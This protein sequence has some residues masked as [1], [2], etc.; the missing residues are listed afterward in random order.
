MK[1]FRKKK[2][3]PD[4][5][6][7]KPAS[8]DSDNFYSQHAGHAPLDEYSDSRSVRETH[9]TSRH[10]PA[11]RRESNN[12]A[13]DWALAVLLLRAVL[14]IVLL[15]GGFFV[16]KLVLNRM[17][18]P[19]DKERQRWEAATA[20][21]EQSSES[22]VIPVGTP[23]AP[24]TV[25]DS[26]LIEQRIG[27]WDLAAQLLH[28]AEGLERRGI[29]EDAAQRLGQVLRI[30]PD[31]RAAQQLLVDIYMRR[32]LYAEAIPLCIRLLDQNSQQPELQMSLLKALMASGQNAAVGM[33]AARML[34]DQPNHAGVLSI[35]AA[36][37]MKLG[38]K[39]AALA[40]FKRV[41]ENEDK[42]KGA[43]ES[44]G[45]IY[46][47]QNDYLNAIPY[48]LELTKLDPK[49]DYY[50]MLARCYA[51]QK[52]AGKAVIF[53]GQAA[54][55]FGGEAVSSWFKDPLFDLVRET[56][57]FRSFTDR[58]IGIEGRKA[59]EAISKRTAEKREEPS[60]GLELP[61]RPDMNPLQPRK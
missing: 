17:A 34:L 30:M 7:A 44:C 10:S 2:A 49:P 58:I 37:Q 22:S 9:R 54:G 23:G 47:D 28:S 21:M 57:E 56:P 60:G 29:D 27:Q 50:Q 11:R 16:L 13:S 46:F 31:N 4:E 3:R 45:K 52:E 25:V 59:I 41:L 48:Y 32:G 43:L 42:N 12:R 26:A 24:K 8:P 40:L 1:F 14:I 61:T 38:N 33:L 36:G 19:S 51:Q 20:V 55:L 53:M 18:E 39:E 15:V 35:A 6:R 5:V